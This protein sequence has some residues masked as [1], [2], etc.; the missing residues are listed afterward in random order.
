LLEIEMMTGK[1]YLGAKKFTL[2]KDL[3]VALTKVL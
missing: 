2:R 3:T 1:Q